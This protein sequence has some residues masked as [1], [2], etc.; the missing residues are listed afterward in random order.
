LIK[1]NIGPTDETAVWIEEDPKS[2]LTGLKK[3]SLDA[4]IIDNPLGISVEDSR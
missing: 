1:K 4:D 2:I 3:S